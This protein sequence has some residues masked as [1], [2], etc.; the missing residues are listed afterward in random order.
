MD[1]A[2]QKKSNFTVQIKMEEKDLKDKG[3]EESIIKEKIT[4][5]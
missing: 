2:D 4:K 1:I 5:M 3:V